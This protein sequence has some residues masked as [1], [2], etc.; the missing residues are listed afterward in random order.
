MG[1]LIKL[2]NKKIEDL[3]IYF[4]FTVDKILEGKLI[5][6]PTNSVYGIGGNPFDKNL[7]NRIYEIKY[8]DRDKGFLLL[9]ADLEEAKKI[10]EFNKE[11][12][13]LAK[14]YW[15]GQLTLI[16]KQKPENKFPPELTANQ[17][18]IGLRVPEN[19]IILTILRYLKTRGSFGG[20]IGTSAN[21]SG[22]PPATDAEEISKNF[23][24]LIDLI[25]D[26]GESKSKIPTTIV[27]CTGKELRFL[28]EGKIS[29]EEILNYLKEYKGG[30]E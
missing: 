10:A 25:I 4:E 8:R 15:P 12:E 5:A 29:K 19:K 6:F 26:G 9:V 13:I 24:G 1:L 7:I 18:T 23:F 17:Q 22:E 2:S 21:F 11:A 28:R 16:L 3:E 20:I 30:I 27:D 14:K